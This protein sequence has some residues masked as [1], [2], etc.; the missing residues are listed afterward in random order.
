MKILFFQRF[1]S[2][3]RKQQHL[4]VLGSAFWRLLFFNSFLNNLD[5]SGQTELVFRTFAGDTTRWE[6]GTLVNTINSRVP[7]HG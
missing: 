2:A 3:A 4:V 5:K 7:S 6:A 1:G